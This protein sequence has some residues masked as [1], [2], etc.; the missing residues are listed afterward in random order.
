MTSDKNQPDKPS[1]LERF[2][3][4]EKGGVGEK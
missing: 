2:P 3:G 4:G 1:T